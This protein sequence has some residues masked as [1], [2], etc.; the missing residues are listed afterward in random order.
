MATR[1]VVFSDVLTPGQSIFT[2]YPCPLQG[3]VVA[4]VRQWPN[5]ANGLLDIAW[6]HTGTWVMPNLEEKYVALNDATVTL[7]NLDEPVNYGEQ[8]WVRY[9]NRDS[10]NN[11]TPVVTLTIQ[12][13][14]K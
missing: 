1:E 14:K 6:G 10:A 2:D 12:G 13:E 5:G 4:C 9:R 7:E 3:K 11:H 8:L